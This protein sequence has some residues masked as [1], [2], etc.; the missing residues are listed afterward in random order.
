MTTGGVLERIQRLEK[1]QICEKIS[2]IEN[3]HLTQEGDEII[4]V[5]NEGYVLVG[6]KVLRC[7]W[8]GKWSGAQPQ[9]KANNTEPIG[10]DLEEESQ[11]DTYS[12]F[13][14]NESLTS[15]SSGKSLEEAEL[16]YDDL[17][18]D[19]EDCGPKV[20]D[21]V[22]K[23]INSSCT[24]KPAKEQF[25]SIQR[26]YLRPENCEFLKAPRVNRELWDDLHDKTKSPEV[27]FQA[28]QRNLIKGV[29][30]VIMLTNKM[31]NAKKDKKDTIAV[32]DVYDLA[33][34][35]LTL[36]GNSVYE[37]LMKR[38]ESLKSEVAPAYKSLCH[39]SQPITTMLF[40]RISN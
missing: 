28:F 14:P 7:T 6:E 8:N 15:G 20:L 24:K 3:G 21:G 10:L 22:A 18:K 33:V 17:F 27:F 40:E 9:C 37:F 26:K 31:V 38:R 16:P 11:A 2:F 36:L 23:R 29:I 34:D 5:C 12:V 25:Q 30:P 39:E 13:D 32:S 19:S 1:E 4:F 35:A